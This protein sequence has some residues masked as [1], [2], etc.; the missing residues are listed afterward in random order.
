MT[1]FLKFQAEQ[2]FSL[3][4][5][6]FFVHFPVEPGKSLINSNQNILIENKKGAQFARDQMTRK[7]DTCIQKK[8]NHNSFLMIL[9]L[10]SPEDH[11]V[12]TM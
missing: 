8:S 4:K 6:L 1:L 11:V 3:P 12:L 5:S 9:K 10:Q 2:Q 7:N